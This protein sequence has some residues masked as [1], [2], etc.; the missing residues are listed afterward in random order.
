MGQKLM[1]KEDEQFILEKYEEGCSAGQILKL[2][3]YK[4]KTTKTIYDIIRRYGIKTKSMTDY[5]VINSTAF[6]NIDTEEKAYF[7]GM[8]QADGWITQDR[9]SVGLSLTDEYM[10]EKFKKFIGSENSIIKRTREGCLDG[11]QLIVTHPV[12]YSSLKPYNIS[13]KY[14]GQYIPNISEDL[15]NHYIRGLFDGDGTICITKNNT[16]RVNFLGGLQSMS[17]LSYILAKLTDTQPTKIYDNGSVV[18]IQYG[19]REVIK[20]ILDYMYKDANIFLTRKKDKM[21]KFYG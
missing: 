16:I 2:L 15:L 7:L 17:Q 6:L 5:T 10:V 18:T 14:R 3:N 8:L 12:L 1:T 11:F 9:D 21:E 4:Y 19:D 13:D 20:K